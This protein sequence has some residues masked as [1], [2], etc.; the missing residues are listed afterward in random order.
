MFER[1]TDRARATVVAAQSEARKLSHNYIGTE[2]ILLGLLR[3]DDSAA[4]RALAEAGVPVEQARARIH[5]LV[6]RGT[7]TPGGHIP[8]TPRAKGSL[9]AALREARRLRHD[10]IGPE[11]LL[12]GL[13][14]EGEGTAAR[15]LAEAGADITRVREAVGRL[16][17]AE[18]G[19]TRPAVGAIYL[20]YRREE[21][22]W[23]AG[24][25]VDELERQL[26]PGRV[27][28]DAG[29]AAEV[30]PA[31][32]IVLVLIDPGWTEPLDE[33]VAAEVELAASLDKRIIPVLIE[34]ATMPAFHPVL[35]DLPPFPL[36]HGDFR[37]RMHD[38]VRLFRSAA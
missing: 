37:V 5:E 27:M 25:I 2:H 3:D 12:L 13:M 7:E 35:A 26:G 22:P 21:A 34:G 6:P 20:S 24:R 8:F 38:L 30:L 14:L 28:L 19:P 31:C 18:N 16:V 11:H 9:E 15:A 10:F 23:T 29:P 32:G 4:A 17:T 33:A 36:T 1:F